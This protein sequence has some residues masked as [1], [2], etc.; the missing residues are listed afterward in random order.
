MTTLVTPLLAL[1][2]A[3]LEAI[4]VAGFVL[5]VLNYSLL[6]FRVFDAQHAAYFLFN[7]IAALLVL[8]GLLGSF[9][10]A[11]AM[12]QTFWIA[13]S[14]IAIVLRLRGGRAAPHKAS[15]TH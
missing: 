3:L 2:P 13:I 4:G 7:L 8:I 14:A 1:D 5:Y 10:L 9:N 11:S 12:I 6:T 15:A